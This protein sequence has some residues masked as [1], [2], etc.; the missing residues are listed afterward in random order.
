VKIAVNVDV[1]VAHSV[2]ADVKAEKLGLPKPK[3]GLPQPKLEEKPES[4]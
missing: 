3:P 2:I 1:K 4:Q